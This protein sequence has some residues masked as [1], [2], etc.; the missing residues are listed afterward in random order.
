[1]ALVSDG[2]RH[3][4]V[5]RYAGENKSVTTL[6]HLPPDFS[7]VQNNNKVQRKNA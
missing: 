1:M 3:L 2:S 6:T 7:V 5:K 4:A